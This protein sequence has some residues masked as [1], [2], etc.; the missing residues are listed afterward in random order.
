[1][2]QCKDIPDQPILDFI[3][4][5]Q[6]GET[7]WYPTEAQRRAYG[8]RVAHSAATWF[9]SDDFKPE[10]S[11]VRAMPEGT[12]PKLALSKMKAMVRK[13]QIEGCACGC[14]GDFTVAVTN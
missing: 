4:M 10:N 6:R 13:G 3:A 12:P 11:V 5:V 1:M 2:M 7:F 8:E 9:W 14:R